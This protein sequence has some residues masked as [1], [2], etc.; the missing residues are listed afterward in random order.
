MSLILTRLF[1][2]AELAGNI[3]QRENYH[4]K[5]DHDSSDWK[6]LEAPAIDRRVGNHRRGD[7]GMIEKT[8]ETT[9]R[10]ILIGVPAAAV[11]AFGRIGAWWFHG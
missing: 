8:P 11:W 2:L 7:M 10:C 3:N 1:V 9:A 6:K 5:S 4:G